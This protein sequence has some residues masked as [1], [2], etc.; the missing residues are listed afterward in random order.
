MKN[1]ETIAE[2]EQKIEILESFLFKNISSKTWSLIVS[3]Y[4]AANIRLCQLKGERPIVI[5]YKPD[6]II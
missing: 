4:H 2:L 5:Y 6:H 3:R 1:K